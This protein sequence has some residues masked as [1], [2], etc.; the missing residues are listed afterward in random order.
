MSDLKNFFGLSPDRFAASQKGRG[1]EVRRTSI[2][3][4]PGWSAATTGGL[5]KPA[6]QIPVGDQ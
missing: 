6:K 4:A 1:S 2:F 5:S 3:V